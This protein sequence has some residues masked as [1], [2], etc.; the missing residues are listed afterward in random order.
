MGWDDGNR[1][2]GRGVSRMMTWGRSRGR[3]GE[4]GEGEIQSLL[5]IHPLSPR[6]FPSTPTSS[7]LHIHH[8]P[9]DAL[10]LY[11][12]GYGI[13]CSREFAFLFSLHTINRWE[14]S[15]NKRLEGEEEGKGKGKDEH[16][17]LF[18]PLLVR[19]FFCLLG[20]GVVLLVL[21][22]LQLGLLRASC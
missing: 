14:E 20:V 16:L 15:R 6:S 10:F 3:W 22:L 7:F 12:V 17:V 13:F 19:L 5:R 1:Y 11:M 8:Q 4:G 18:S 21:A 9:R 2:T